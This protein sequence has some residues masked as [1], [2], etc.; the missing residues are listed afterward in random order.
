MKYIHKE[1]E[2]AQ[3]IAWKK[4]EK[5]TL[6][7]YISEGTK[8]EIIWD[9][10]PSSCPPIGNQEEY[11][12]YYSK[13][14]LKEAILNEQGFICCYCNQTIK[15][16]HNTSIEHLQDK[17]SSPNLTLEYKNLLASCNGGQKDP[18]PRELH[19]D[20][21]KK[22]KIL[23]LSPLDELTE[24]QL[25]FS[26]NGKIYHNCEKG[27]CTIKRLNLAISKLERLR[28]EAIEP[29]IF[30]DNSE[31]INDE[32]AKLLLEKI[33]EREA[34]NQFIEFCSAIKS[35]IEREILNQK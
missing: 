16:D 12:I 2:P 10:F 5:A 26:V 8:G 30:D 13:S 19:C 34:E 27:K 24:L 32:D 18:A 11:L 35:V 28:K 23:S 20:A 29:F 31:V 7:R 14:E 17:A 6:E 33:Y 3:F 4:Q 25:Y 1:E 21:K 15:N 9:Y 22:D